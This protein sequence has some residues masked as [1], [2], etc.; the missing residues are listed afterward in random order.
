ML[1]KYFAEAAP[2]SAVLGREYTNR[3][4]GDLVLL[5]F[6]G[7]G[8]DGLEIEEDIPLGQHW[9]VLRIE[10]IKIVYPLISQVPA[11]KHNELVWQ[12]AQNWPRRM[13]TMCRDS[14]CTSIRHPR[15][16]GIRA[17]PKRR[18]YWSMSSGMPR[19]WSGSSTPSRRSWMNPSDDTISDAARGSCVP[20]EGVGSSLVL[21]KS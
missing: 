16:V 13:T 20:R 17:V 11:E 10:H 1:S 3:R 5:D 7:V 4:A 2:D 15:S 9:P 21:S 6:I 19:T 14:P 12:Y 18:V 8:T